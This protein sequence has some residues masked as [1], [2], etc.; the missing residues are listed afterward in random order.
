MRSN[1]ASSVHGGLCHCK[2]S[3]RVSIFRYLT[4]HSACGTC[5]SGG[6]RKIAPVKVRQPRAKPSHA[7][8]M[9]TSVALLASE[10]PPCID[11][12]FPKSDRTTGGGF[13]SIILPV[14]QTKIFSQFTLKIR[15][16]PIAARIVTE[17]ILD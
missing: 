13:G 5:V 9:S 12:E 14:Q 3:S 11:H 17:N 10:H 15:A 8:K 7:V 2:T 6:N 1:L 4:C 16:A